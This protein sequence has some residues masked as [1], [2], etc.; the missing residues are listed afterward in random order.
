MIRSCKIS[1]DGIFLN[2][3]KQTIDFDVSEDW[4]KQLPQT[5]VLS[6]DTGDERDYRS[7][8]YGDL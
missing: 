3:V 5:R 6:R 8:P 4:K 1:A 2:G 7:S